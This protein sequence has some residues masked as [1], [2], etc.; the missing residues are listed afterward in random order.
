MAT[1]SAQLIDRLGMLGFNA[2][3]VTLDSWSS[4]IAALACFPMYMVANVHAWTSDKQFKMPVF[5][6]PGFEALRESVEIGKQEGQLKIDEYDAK[7]V[8]SMLSAA[9]SADRVIY[10]YALE[11]LKAFLVLAAPAFADEVRTT[12][13]RMIVAVAKAS[14]EGL[15]GTGDKVS[16]EE[17][18]CIEHIAATLELSGSLHAATIIAGLV[19]PA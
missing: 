1:S 4:P 8:D 9:K 19:K 17:L 6:I 14:G 5:D 16:R 11:S 10:E 15:F 12:V 2:S 7:V 18:L 3:G 13:T